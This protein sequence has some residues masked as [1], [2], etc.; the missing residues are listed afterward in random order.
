MRVL[1]VYPN[2]QKGAFSPQMGIASLSAVLKGAGHTCDLYDVTV[3]PDGKEVPH[4]VKKVKSYKPDLIAYSIRS[5]E[6]GLVRALLEAVPKEEVPAVAGG[7]HVTV[8]TDEVM[9]SFD[10]AIRGEAEEALL[11]TVT[12]LEA[13]QHIRDVKN[14]WVRENGTIHK[15]ELGPLG[16]NLDDLPFPDWGLF[17]ARHLNN[18]YLKGSS[19]VRT[20]QVVGTFEGSRG[21]IFTCTYCSSPAVM[22]MYGGP[23]WRREKSATR[24]A[25]EI[26]AFEKEFGLDFVYFVDEIFLT[27]LPR[28]RE[29]RD[30]FQ[31]RVKKP[32][33]FMERPE[34]MTEE[35]V[36]IIAEA[37]AAAVA[38]GVESGDEAFRKDVLD[39]RMPQG[40]IVEAFQIAKKYGLHT[41]AFNMVGLP[42]ETKEI[43]ESNF[44]LLRTLKPDSFQA[45]IFYPLRGT[46]LYTLCKEKG[47]LDSDEMPANYYEQS[48]LTMPGGLSKDEIL[49]YRELISMYAGRRSRFAG[50]AFR[51]L[52]RHPLWFRLAYVAVHASDWRSLSSRM[53]RLGP[54]GGSREIARR[55][56]V[57]IR[58]SRG[59]HLP[60]TDGEAIVMR[61]GADP[62]YK[63]FNPR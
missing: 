55:L 59:G 2:V 48:V 44:E 8:A 41:H 31:E 1:F 42:G 6:V 23:S 21:C 51:F 26:N 49:R 38:I 40:S 19:F 39:R 16:E 56:G 57:V 43:I 27:K 11:E 7:H 63:D 20:G 28:L 5:N 35:K 29:I 62:I 3:V 33:T 54:I 10:I 45:S 12:R 9:E 4:F 14:V 46:E 18:H 34:L 30:V 25:D 24:M 37:G 47:Y 17:D 13:G 58:G 61:T 22:G 60:K 53:T 50:W 52:A 15:N 36:K 32:F